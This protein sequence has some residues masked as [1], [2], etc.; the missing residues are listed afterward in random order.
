[1]RSS[2]KNDLVKKLLDECGARQGKYIVHCYNQS[3]IYPAKNAVYHSKT[4]HIKVH[5]H[6]IQLAL[7]C[8]DLQVDKIHAD[9]NLVDM[10]IKVVATEK[11]RI[12]KMHL[13]L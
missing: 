4:K 10:L 7:E 13:S 12:C 3:V 1:M 9:K 8:G 6:F 11:H 2:K 5:C